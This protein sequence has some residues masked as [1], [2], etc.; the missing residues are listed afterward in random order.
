MRV[1]ASTTE[2]FSVASG[3]A[4]FRMN[5]LQLS[6][7]VK[8]P[9]IGLG[10]GGLVSVLSQLLL[11]YSTP[12]ELENAIRTA[13]DIGYRHIDTAAMYENEHIT[14]NVLADL[15]RSG[16]IKREELFITSKLP[17]SSN[18]PDLVE[19]TLR[20]TLKDLQTD[21][22]DLYLIHSPTSTMPSP[23]GFRMYSG[24]NQI[25]KHDHVDLTKTWQA[26]EKVYEKGLAKAIGLS[27]FNVEQIQNI[28]HAA[29]VKPHNLQIEVHI[30]FP[31][32]ELHTLCT[33]LNIAVTAFAPL[34]CPS[35]R[36]KDGWPEKVAI[37]NEIVKELAKKYGK[38]PAQILLRHLL[39]R[40][41]VVI[42]K[43]TNAE[44]LREN[45]NIFDFEISSDDMNKLNRI[46]PQGRL[47][48]WSGCGLVV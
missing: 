8:I 16:K 36:G 26:M 9:L 11:K 27:N 35:R 7:G 4:Q 12:V 29:K 33:S 20:A 13:I 31:Q 23:E 42:P 15:I 28:Y 43:S 2:L 1:L 32:R 46:E 41:I 17:P 47:Y 10:T 45:F 38:T 44:R 25:Q 14:G 22:V 21:Y 37:D 5:C 6:N 39:Q 19:P 40:Q 48:T 24:A 34:G 18:R 3:K 30:Y